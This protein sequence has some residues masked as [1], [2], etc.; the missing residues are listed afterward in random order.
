M[1][2]A[3]ALA[4]VAPFHVLVFSKTAGFRH[5]SIPTGVAMFQELAG[6]EGYTVDATEDATKFTKENLA[7]YDVVVFLNT[8]QDVLAGDQEAALQDFVE[9]K[10]KGWLG[11]HAAAD[12][13][14]DWPWYGQLCGAWFKSHPAIQKV[15]VDVVD[16]RFPATKHLPEKWV[17]TDELYNYRA[18]PVKGCHI[19][20]KLDESTYKGGEMNGDHPIV[21]YHSVGKG[22]SFYCGLGHTKEAYADKDFRKLVVGGLK[23][24]AHRA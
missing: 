8:T 24:A 7:K 15:T 5:D 21:W 17:W 6:G 13:E 12:T 4:T 2:T 1:I 18:Q 20:A 16:R 22:R 19:L 11:V 14:Y 10:G 3:L 9:K 23:W